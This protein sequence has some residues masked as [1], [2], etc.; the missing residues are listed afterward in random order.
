MS[1]T[2]RQGTILAFWARW[3]SVVL[4]NYAGMYSF[5]GTKKAK[6]LRGSNMLGR[7]IQ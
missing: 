3:E 4:Y 2:F 6:V 7:L 1:Q 5:S